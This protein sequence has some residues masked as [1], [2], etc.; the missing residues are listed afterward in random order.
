MPDPTCQTVSATEISALLGVSPYATPFMLYERFANGADIDDEENNR[1]SWG[2]KM[3]PLIIEQAK[4]D[5]ALEVVPNSLP[6]GSQA[7]F[8]RGLLG[9][10]R[11]ATVIMPDRGPGAFDAKC[12]FDYRMWMERW[13]EGKAPPRHVELQLQ[14]QMYVGDGE[15]PFDHGTIAAWIA[16]EQK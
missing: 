4:Q 11:D 5:L 10:T 3:E 14:C 1:M 6:D 13:N 7:Y 2:K 8:R 15:K 16:G 12:V 9:A